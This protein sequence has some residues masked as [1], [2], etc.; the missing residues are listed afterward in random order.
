MAVQT[1][2]LPWPL[3][4]ARTALYEPVRASPLC[5]GVLQPAWYAS[6]TCSITGQ[7]E[8]VAL[9][10]VA[11]HP[12]HGAPSMRGVLNWNLS[13]HWGQ[14]STAA[15]TTASLFPCLQS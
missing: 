11:E 12:M 15:A 14:L 4:Q 10:G 7:A 3:D 8:F 13:G 5:A 6:I 2:F 1:R 9:A